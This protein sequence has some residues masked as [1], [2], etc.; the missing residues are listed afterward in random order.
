MSQPPADRFDTAGLRAAVLDAWRA[1]PTRYRE[2]ANVE[3]DYA[4]GAYRDR[5]I[6]ELAQNAADAARTAGVPGR[7]R[8]TT[9]DDAMQVANT[10]APLDRV[11]VQS[12]A[13]MRASAKSADAV[14]KFGVGFAA[15][16]SVSD[17]PA[18]LSRDGGVRFSRT[19]SAALLRDDAAL[20]S[21]LDEREPPVLRLPFA[22]DRMP[23]TLGD[24]T[25]YETAVVLPWRDA[26]ARERANEAV[27]AIDDA[28]FIAL[29]EI[30]ELVVDRGDGTTQRWTAAR[31]GDV[32]TVTLD[33][34]ERR[35]LLSTTNGQWSEHDRADA[36]TELRSRSGWSL[37]WAVPVDRDGALA[38]WP[39]SRA[40]TGGGAAPARVVHAPTP[41]DEPLAL[42]ALLVA[43][44]PVDASRR[45]LAD[46][47][48]TDVVLSAASEAY[49]DLVGR[50][51]SHIGAEAV[52]LV[53]SP[54]L[55]GPV[56]DRMRTTI[57]E[58]LSR[59]RWLPRAHDAS[60]ATPSE[61]VAVEPSNPELVGIVAEHVSDLLAPAW[62]SHIATLRS[63]GLSVRS[64]PEVWDAVAPL[65]LAASEWHMVY[66]AA[67]S[68][69]RTALEG[70]P[71]PLADG[72]VMRDV[73]HCVLPEGGGLAFA[74]QL[75]KL[76]LAVVD[77]EASHP[78]LERLGA[79][80]FDPRQLGASLPELVRQ[81]VA[82]DEAEA[83]EVVAAAASALAVAG[84]RPGEV[85]A[86]GDVP[87]ATQGG[88]WVPAA[89]VVL[90][91]STL[92]RL[93]GESS[94]L[95]ASLARDNHDGWLALGVLGELTVVTIGDVVLDPGAWDD[96]MVEGGEWCEDVA[97][98]LDADSP[99][100]VLAD[101]VPVVRGL[102]FVE[103]MDAERAWQ[104][105]RAP[106]IRSAVLEPALVVD[107]AGQTHAVP[108]PAAFWLSGLPL[109]DG[110]PAIDLRLPDDERLAP[111]FPTLPDPGD[112]D[113]ELLI[114]MGIHTSLDRWLK[115]PEGVEEL[116]TAMGDANLELP[117]VLM[118]PLY[119]A[120]AEV[121]DE[122]DELPDAPQRVRALK[123]GAWQV[124]DADEVVVAVAPHHAAVLTG[125]FVPGNETLAE[126][127]DVEVS[128]D[129]ACDAAAIAASG[130][131]MSVPTIVG[132]LVG[133]NRVVT[134]YR[135]H[136]ALSVNDVEVDWW[137]TDD[138]E[139]HACTVDGLA[140]ALAWASGQWHRRW[141]LAALMSS[142]DGD[143]RLR[144]ESYYD[145]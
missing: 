91:E 57:R 58:R 14:G 53:P 138:G 100:D 90:P 101:S 78:L 16:L 37:T 135:E 127:L 103:A 125:A 79:R 140:R 81:T 119:A 133:G 143:D 34:V 120:V 130:S 2:D 1:S 31:D 75:T 144:V 21:L 50:F 5:L 74:E 46:G 60:R 109:F 23:P 20:R 77:G 94:L 88:A 42:P 85:A 98:R 54:D 124:V 63:L 30:S 111:F 29:P 68:L 104:L 66:E 69:D 80:P 123:G 129:A 102:Q 116:L 134:E 48:M 106:G 72:R 49:C 97:D 115:Q 64:W 35:W 59:T 27:A 55:V 89:R 26:A 122:R 84:V 128:N 9:G 71:V 24:A 136:D 113:A 61:L 105:L 126:L 62:S 10:G 22:D 4:L 141:E 19:E 92:G 52:R 65:G 8:I 117:A 44:V 76:G 45:R 33:G 51:V 132:D 40:A 3:E 56:D 118:P 87:V 110:R 114:A 43:D 121:V 99:S 11:G 32:L 7:M 47:R 108:S 83:R 107:P 28:L 17:E 137:V 131:A 67:S 82:D 15:V 18:V 95:D 12:L 6:V 112:A 36:P 13:A 70:L 86:L 25:P 93:V 73:R 96:V 38:P 145:R 139:V 41:T 142:A 39:S